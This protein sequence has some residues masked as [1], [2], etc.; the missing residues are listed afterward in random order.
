MFMCGRDVAAGAAPVVVERVIRQR[1]EG[2]S[3][4]HYR[5]VLN[6]AGPAAVLVL[7]VELPLPFRPSAEILGRRLLVL[8]AGERR[9]VEIGSLRGMP[10][11]TER[12]RAAL[13]LRGA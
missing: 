2:V 3:L 9:E 4:W 11:E 7:S 8:A 10:L 6:N 13:L 5:A 1:G 12:V